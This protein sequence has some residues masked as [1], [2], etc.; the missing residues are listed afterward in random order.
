MA[1]E[2]KLQEQT[3]MTTKPTTRKIA[4][5]TYIVKK[6]THSETAAKAAA[7]NIRKKY[8]KGTGIAKKLGEGL[9]AVYQ[10]KSAGVGPATKSTKK[11]VAQLPKW[12][13]TYVAFNHGELLST[14]PSRD[15]M[16]AEQKLATTDEARRS[17]AHRLWLAGKERGTPRDI[18]L[19]L[20]AADVK[21]YKK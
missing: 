3:I 18:Y 8:G 15:V 16:R 17:K 14:L 4:G 6:T 1:T 5:K 13:P 21:K 7:S 20:Y 12:K 10:L 11:P 9:Y 19:R 2:Y